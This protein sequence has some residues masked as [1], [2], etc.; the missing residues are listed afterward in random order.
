MPLIL[1]LLLGSGLLAQQKDD[2]I[3]V[4]R[5]GVTLV[6]VDIA[7]TTGAGRAIGD[8]T[9][10]D[11]TVFDENERQEIAYF[12]RES[13]PLDL[14]L[15]LDISGSMRRSLEDVASVTRA[16]L[17]QLH[18]GD[19]VGL[20]L[21]SRRAEVIQ[22]LTPDFGATQHKILDS[23]YKQ[24][25]G[26][27]TLINESL[28]AAGDYMK[29]QPVKGRRAIL[30]VTDNEGLNYKS[31]DAEVVRAML[32]ADTVLNA[33]VVRKGARPPAVKRAGYTNPDFAPPDVFSISERTGGEA[34]EGLGKVGELFPKMI[35]RVR[36][37]YFIQYPAP[38]AEA[39]AF[40]RVRVELTPAARR[41]YPGAVVRAREGYYAAQ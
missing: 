40:R 22:E 31:P 7:V 21:F 10:Q 33:L 12:G 11:F 28:I 3:P 37:R 13:E 26:S 5:S 17:A 18:A 30:I 35:E 27:G 29:R 1:I 24:S 20:M 19:R 6:K 34:V 2:E 16:A 41:K 38:H 39:G 25:L 36:S 4:F 15:L 14:L 32:S 23:I 9:Q 8:L